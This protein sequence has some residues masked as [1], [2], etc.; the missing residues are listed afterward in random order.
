M[1]LILKRMFDY[2]EMGRLDIAAKRPGGK[3]QEVL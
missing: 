1:D 2:T 3:G